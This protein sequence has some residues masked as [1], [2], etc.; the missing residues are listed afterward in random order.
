MLLT[1]RVYCLSLYGNNKLFAGR[2]NWARHRNCCR[3]VKAQSLHV[4]LSWR[5]SDFKFPCY[6]ELGHVKDDTTSEHVIKSEIWSITILRPMLKINL[7][8]TVNQ[9]LVPL[10]LGFSS[11][12]N[13]SSFSSKLAKWIPWRWMNSICKYLFFESESHSVM[14]NSLRPHGLHSPWNSPGQNT[15]VGSVSLL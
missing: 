8:L 13:P 14:S 1:T 5:K 10:V 6:Q 12:V 7:H 9:G 11:T 2:N 3:K 15:G 4:S